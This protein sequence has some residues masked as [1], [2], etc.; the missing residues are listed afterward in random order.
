MK[1]FFILVSLIGALQVA[2]QTTSQ[3]EVHKGLLWEIS[4]NGLTKTSYLYGTMHVSG[5]IA[6]HLGEEFFEGLA[7]VDA[8]ALESN[9]IIW[10]DEIVESP[11]ANNYLGRYAIESQAYKG[12]YQK[13][14]KIKLPEN[15]DFAKALS[16]NHFLANWMLYRESA[17]N[18]EFEED[19]FLDM[20]IYQAGSKQN[21]PVYSLENFTQTSAFSMM[22]RIPDSEPKEKSEWYKKLTKEKSYFEILE[23]SYRNQDLDMLDSLQKETSS[24]NNMKYMLYLRNEIMADNIDSIIQSGTSLFIGIGAAH[25]ANSKG[26]IGLLRAKGYSVEPSSRTFSEKAKLEKEKLSK[27][28]KSVPFSY[29]FSTELFSM[30][31]PG[32][33]YETPSEANERQFFSPELTNGTFYTVKLLS[34]YNQLNGQSG[35]RYLEKIDSLLFE[36]IPGKIISKDRIKLDGFHGLDIVNKT[37]TG[38]YQR[39]QIVETPLHLLILKMGGKHD[40]VQKE[41]ERFFNS[42]ELK[43]PTKEWNEVATIKKDFVVKIP[44]YYHIKG[45]TKATSMYTHPEIEAFDVSD[46][47]Y[48]LVKR[49]ALHDF[50]FIEEDDFELKRLAKKFYKELEIDSIETNLDMSQPYPTS[51]SYGKTKEGKDLTIKIVVKGAYYYLLATTSASKKKSQQFFDSFAFTEQDYTFP[52]E[53]RIDSALYFTVNSNYV[54]PNPY[55]QMIRKGYERKRERKQKEDKSYLSSKMKQT[56]YSENYERILVEYDKFHRYQSFK[57]LDTLFNREIRYFTK[58]EKLILKSRQSG[59]VGPNQFVEAYF[60]DTNSS[61]MIRKKYLVSKGTLYTLTANL[62]TIGP[63]S[64]FVESF[65]STFAPSDSSSQLELTESKSKLFFEAI[66]S[67]DSTEKERALKSVVM[68]DDFDEKDLNKLKEVILTYSFPSKHLEA[69]ANLIQSLGGIKNPSITPFLANLYD[70]VEDTAMFQLAILRALSNQ[71]TKESAKLLVDLIEKDIPLSSSTWGTSSIFYPFFDSLSLTKYIY[72]DLFNF[73]FVDEYQKPI[74]DLMIKAIDS[75]ELKKNILK[76]EYKQILREAKIELKSQISN[77]QTAKA[78]EEKRKYYYT[79]YKNQGNY[80]LIRYCRMLMPYY[81]KLDVREF[82]GKLEKVQDYQIQTDLACLLI[83][84]QKEVSQATW[85]KLAADVINKHYLYESLKEIDKLDLFPSAELTQEGI[86]QSFLYE[87]GFDFSKDS[88]LFLSKEKVEV[89]GEEGFVYFFQSKG[90]NDDNWEL[91]F[92]GL[93]PLDLTKVNTSNLFKKKGLKIGKDKDVKELIEEKMKEIRVKDH[94]R[95]DES[96]N[97]NGGGYNYF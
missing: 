79:S 74:Y 13:A 93:Q 70:K 33:V 3:N 1:Q 12:F 50:E 27:T 38:D 15:K 7:S 81:A 45:N 84:N 23:D 75:S 49:A 8:I 95:A 56:Y 97:G 71:K 20:F 9:P 24:R 30:K 69:K 86:C 62:D 5:R 31:T 6:F 40:F 35:Q 59:N 76:K 29:S 34:K 89:K 39:Y 91:D 32:K 92:I 68:I 63:N 77:E 44:S 41:S 80:K 61:R 25:L 72:P 94:P 36:N 58:N 88:L 65:F 96:E 78:K 37:R 67:S 54:S 51:L 48:Y 14:F 4:G 26:V 66:Y 64:K 73:T 82:F 46:S 10:L 90:K 16:A 28:K 2:A 87:R 47:S 57:H 21:K 53:E 11:F 42:I 83:L 85:N 22:A 43:K 60:T 18:K 17:Q 55:T 52:F 19:T